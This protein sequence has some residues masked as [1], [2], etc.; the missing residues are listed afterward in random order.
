MSETTPAIEV[1][2]VRRKYA[3]RRGDP[4]V[5]LDELS[6]SI[7]AGQ[8]VALLGPNGSGKSTL[9]RMLATLDAPDGGSVRVFGEDASA[10]PRAVRA[11]LGVVFQSVGLDKLLTGRENLR[12]QGAL[13]GMSAAESDRRAQ[14]LAEWLGVQD[15]MRDRVGTLS[16]GL[17]RRVDL[18]RALLAGPD[19]LLLDEPT[20][21]LDFD[22]RSGFL[23]VVSRAHRERGLTVV[24]TTHLMDEAE[25]ADRV[26]MLHG[27]RI[28]RDGSPSELRSGFGETLLRCG[29]EA[30]PHLSGLE[31][32]ESGGELLVSGDGETLRR[33]SHQLISAGLPFEVGPPT[34]GDVFTSVTGRSLS[35]DSIDEEAVA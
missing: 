1:S 11:R 13:F 32:R 25:R 18:A 21:G 15:R 2:D 7:P 5:A 29:H 28:V 3:R 33:V 10:A 27:G 12:R 34:L 23:D 8:S 31:V 6:L 24:M 9:L 20:N 19:L 4:V 14:E 22:A 16:G 35:G 30:R 26:V 17:A